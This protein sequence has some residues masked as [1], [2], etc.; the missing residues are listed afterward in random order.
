M[1]FLEHITIDG[2]I[3]NLGLIDVKSSPLSKSETRFVIPIS[4]P[5]KDIFGVHESSEIIV[6]DTPGF[7]DTQSA[8]IDIA[9]CLGTIK[10]V[11]RC[12]SVKIFALSSYRS[13]GDRGQDI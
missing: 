8:E 7:S 13:L 9:N 2:P 1:K 10:V 12:K 3:T 6:C 11:K 4:I 5:L